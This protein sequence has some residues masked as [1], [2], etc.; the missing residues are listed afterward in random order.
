MERNSSFTKK[1]K[2]NYN[3]IKFNIQKK[4]FNTFFFFIPFNY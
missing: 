2:K 4:I 3:N 1:I